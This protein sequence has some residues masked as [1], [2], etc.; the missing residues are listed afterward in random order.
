MSSMTATMARTTEQRGPGGCVGGD[1]ESPE[2]WVD[3]YGSQLY[4][5]VLARVR[6]AAAAEEVVQDTFLAALACGRSFEGRS[7]TKTWLLGI[8]RHKTVDYFRQRSRERASGD[9]MMASDADPDSFDGGGNWTVEPGAWGRNPEDAVDGAMVMQQLRRALSQ[10]SPTL[11]DA[12]VLRE[13]DD[14]DPDDICRILGCTRATLWVRLHR[15]RAKLRRAL[16][17]AGV[18]DWGELS[19]VEQARSGAGRGNERGLADQALAQG[20]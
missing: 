16:V 4:R 12:F 15:A 1:L 13:I 2:I 7:S 5:F 14:V 3:R 6:D 11:A 9:M 20:A 19:A 10:L 17:E 18:S 8:A